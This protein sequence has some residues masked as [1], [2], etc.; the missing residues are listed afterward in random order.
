MK[1]GDLVR[2]RSYQYRDQI[3]IIIVVGFVGAIGVRLLCGRVATYNR[4]SLEVLSEGR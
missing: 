1:V 3:G 2:P 4:G